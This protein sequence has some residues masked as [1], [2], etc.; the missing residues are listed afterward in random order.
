MN[1]D[2]SFVAGAGG[3][4]LPR[5]PVLHRA[6]EY[7]PAGFEMLREM[8]TRHFWYRGRHRF[9]L[10]A[11]KRALRTLAPGRRSC[12][13]AI[14]LGAGCGGWVAYLSAREPQLFAELALADSSLHALDR[15]AAVVPAGT[16]RF[17]IDLLRLPWRERWDAAFLLD[18]L[19]HIPDD[20]A[21]LKQIHASLRPGGY[22]FV[23]TPALR[24]F[25]TYIDDLG[26]HVRRY[27]RPDF[28]RLAEASSFRLWRS[29][30]FMFFLSP[31][32]LL[33]RLRAPDLAKMTPEDILAHLRRTHGV[34]P[35]PFNSVLAC[36]FSCE[37]PLGWWLP[38]P[39]GTSVLGI[40]RKSEE[41]H[42]ADRKASH[43]PER[44]GPEAFPA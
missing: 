17:Q 26:H 20:V 42:Y 41:T 35:K 27:S 40:F 3:V 32:L 18:V 43:A 6:D 28:A 37:T 22:L 15:A 4:L 19:E 8:Q 44:P 39:W 16:K 12:L 23:T 14:D 9:L 2:D 24:C 7:D 1:P 34:P 10:H 33:S 38:F 21:V 36:L 13:S 30:Y 31:L 11:L 25:W 5:V 29:R